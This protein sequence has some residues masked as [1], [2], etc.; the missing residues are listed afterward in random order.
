MKYQILVE[1]GDKEMYTATVVG[2]PDCRA[3]ASTAQEAVAG[4]QRA[5]EARLA[6]AE[7]A[8]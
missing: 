6:H 5:L 2:L 1:N 7:L 3:Q 4:V 8:G